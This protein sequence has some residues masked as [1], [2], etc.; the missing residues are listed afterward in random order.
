MPSTTLC[1]I[2]AYGRKYTSREAMRADWDAG[3]DFKID[4]GPYC[5]VRDTSRML[6]MGFTKLEFRPRNGITLDIQL[7]H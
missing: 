1:L 5:S 4:G 7:G 3:K 2:P 6:E